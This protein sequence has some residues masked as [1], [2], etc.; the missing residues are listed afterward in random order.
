MSNKFERIPKFNNRE[1]NNVNLENIP[2]GN[3][4]PEE[5]TPELVERIEKSKI[6]IHDKI[7]L[8]L[9][10]GGLKPSSE[11]VLAIKTQTDEGLTEHMSE[12]EVQEF[13]SIIKESGLPY[14][15]Q[16]REVIREPYS[17]KKEPE[18]QKF[19]RREQ[20]NILIGRSR[21]ELDLLEHALESKSDEMLGRAFGFPPTAIEAFVGKRKPLNRQSLSPD[22]QH[23]DGILFSSPTL[24]QD[25]WQEEIKQGEQCGKFIKEISPQLYNEMKS[26]ALRNL[27]DPNV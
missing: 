15:F 1:R 16:D 2:E 18:I 3:I 12:K 14:R 19:Y 10:K 9:T 23:S 27:E 24:S 22:I 4:T 21:E 26:M 8:L 7:N 6:T 13:L 5:I 11:I 25:N 20:M 17:T